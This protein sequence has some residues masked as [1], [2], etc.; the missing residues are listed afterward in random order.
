MSAADAAGNIALWMAMQVGRRGGWRAVERA[1]RHPDRTQAELLAAILNKNAP[2][3]FGVEHGFDRVRGLAEFRS[4]VPVQTYETL[5]PYVDDQDESGR[6][7]LTVE[8]PVMYARTSGTTGQP[9]DVPIT[10]SGVRRLRDTQRSFATTLYFGSSMFGGKLL[11]IGS[12]A[13]EGHRPSG[14]PY[15]SATGMVYEGMPRLVRRK[16]VLPAAVFDIE[17]Y[18]TRFHAIAALA[19][20]EENIS[21]IVTANPS[22]LVRLRDVVVEHWDQLIVDIERGELGVSGASTARGLDA[23]QQRFQDRPRRAAAL[24]ALGDPAGVGYAQ[25]WP[26]LSGIACWTGGSCGFA[27]AS[28]RPW[29]ADDTR[30]LEAGYSA[31]ELRGSIGVDLDANLCVPTLWDNVFEF[32]AQ[33]VWEGGEPTFRS[34]AEIEPGERYYVFVTTQDGLYRYDMNDI[35][36]VNGYFNQTPC[37]AFVQKGK[38]VTNITGEKLYESQVLDALS[39]AV[40]TGDTVDFFI[41]LA[42]ETAPGYRLYVEG[43]DTVDAAVHLGAAVESA[44]RASNIEY[45]AK[46]ASGRLRP[47]EAIALLPGTGDRYRRHSVN[48]GQ[49]DAQFKYLAL[50]Y[51][52]DCKFD[53]D[54]HRLRAS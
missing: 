41:V 20:A 28:L 11:G 21:G 44:L 30:V 36:E 2:T 45:E 6:P 51:A 19:V 32:V 5:R 18:D 42:D 4:A 26:R 31:S 52:R 33:D 13:V 40:Q 43:P 22:T 15:G 8:A 53:I 24:A 14:R 34:V 12:A 7:A 35:V 39:A 46:R 50:Q 23:V 17:D 47:L 25:L 48:A 9:K 10:P 38:G 1:S 54:Q 3:R 16:Y 29:L 37:I 49:R 27:V